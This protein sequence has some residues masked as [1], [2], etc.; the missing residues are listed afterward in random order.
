M[1]RGLDRARNI[2]G[3][4]GFWLAALAATVQVLLPF[5]VAA[6]IA[7]LNNPVFAS[8]T[9]ICAAYRGE[10]SPPA[11]RDQSNTHH[12][13]VGGCPLC[14]ALA[15]GQACTTAASTPLPTP[16]AAVAIAIEAAVISVPIFLAAAS[17][18]SR[19]PPVIG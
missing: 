12:G 1:A 7:Q 6:A 16:A 3:R 10:T 11:N 19:A 5:F 2:Q 8:L 4:P 14:T 13:L 18:R 17:Y 15:A 9:F